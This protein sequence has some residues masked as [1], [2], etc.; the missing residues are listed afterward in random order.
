[1]NKFF[2]ALVVL[3]GMLGLIQ[4]TNYAVIVAGSDYYYNYRHQSD[5]A[6]HYHILIER[7][8]QPEH[9]IT[10]MKDDLATDSQNP[11]PGATYVNHLS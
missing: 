1:M 2:V 5:I 11:F 7:G 4:A 10:F 8:Y 3:V 9:I 6:H